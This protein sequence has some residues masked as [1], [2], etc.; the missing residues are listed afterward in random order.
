[1]TLESLPNEL[2]FDIFE[3]LDS[4]QV[5]RAFHGLNNRF[6]ELIFLYF[7]LYFLNFRSVSKFDFDIICKQHLPYILDKIYSLCLSDNDETPDLTSLFLAQSFQLNQFIY[8]HTLTI[9][10]IHSF[11]LLNRLVCQC[12]CLPHFTHLNLMQCGYYLLK[13]D[14]LCLT[15]HIWS[16]TKL[17]HCHFDCFA[18]GQTNFP[19]MTPVS[20]TL[21]YLSI[22]NIHCDLNDLSYLLE[23]T[24]NLKELHQNV[25]CI[26]I[27]EKLHIP[28]L[29][30]VS[31]NLTFEGSKY[32]I[33][34]LLINLP[35]LTY[36]TLQLLDICING[37][38]WENMFFDHLKSIKDFKLKMNLEISNEKI[39]DH[40][41]D[42]FRT[43]FWINLHQWYFRCDWYS[44]HATL[45][46]LPYA[47]N[48]FIYS[49]KYQSKSTCLNNDDYWLYNDVNKIIFETNAYH[50]PARFLNIRHLELHCAL[51]E[52]IL[53]AFVRLDRLHSMNVV[54]KND[55][56]YELFEKFI[57]Q[58][59]N[60][61]SLRLK[62]LNDISIEIFQI[63]SKSIE[64]IDLIGNSTYHIRYFNT[65]ECEMILNSS[66]G[67]RCK[68]LLINV[69]NREDII[70]FIDKMFH[71][72]SLIV[73]CK[74]E[75]N[76]E[77]LHQW[78]ENHIPST[79]YT[80]RDH[81][82]ESLHRLWLSR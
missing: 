66:L 68:T 26:F 43:S 6:N 17:K 42:S 57:N 46:S 77:E 81:K 59:P 40:L 73:R 72:R 36:L 37:N 22:R 9:Y 20:L 70:K 69:E 82:D 18:I 64:R 4:I 32:S 15:N 2:L 33:E 75:M 56:S 27:N 23:H 34:N 63:Q 58:A 38:I 29:S 65:N 1:M 11:N 21:E 67:Q 8:L 10:S 61:Y 16:L 35:N 24:P 28:F 41:L 25:E 76:N 44:S 79:S 54:M 55:F 62:Y 12:H 49:N 74:D 60:L 13:S 78:I 30:I 14:I 31:L 45:Y 51:N 50:F 5:V 7:E 53:S 48:E 71:L 39:I 80:S 19:R 52:N 3:L 47:F